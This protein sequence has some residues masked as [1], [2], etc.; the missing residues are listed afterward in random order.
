MRISVFI[1]VGFALI[2]SMFSLTTYINYQLAEQV[3]EN[4]EWVSQSTI[5]VRHSNRFQRN[6]LNMISGLRGYLLS[7]ERYFL[8]TYDSAIAE[9]EEILRELPELMTP[10]SNQIKSLDEIHDLH[11]QWVKD[12]AAPLIAAKNNA[13]ESDS[14]QTVFQRLYK[15][16]LN[17]GFEVRLNNVLMSKMRDFINYEYTLR[18]GRRDELNTIIDKTGRISVL[19]TTTSVVT[20]LLIAIFLA[21]RIST[22]IVH[23]V[24]VSQSIASGNYTV[25]MDATGKDE[26]GKL[27]KSMN[28]M[29]SVLAENISLLK[30][31]NQELDQFA[32]IVSHDMKAPL[33]GIDNVVTWIEEDH[34][35]ELSPK[36]KEYM[37]LIKGRLVRA[38]NLI[39][40]I[41]W[42]SRVGREEVALES[43]DVNQLVYEV[44]ENLPQHNGISI[45]PE[46]NLPTITAER[47]P[48]SQVFTNLISNAIKYHDKPN[49]IIRIYH[50]DDGTQYTFYVAD[51]GP[52]I[53]KNY[54]NKIF[55]IFQTLNEN[56][57]FENTGVGLAIVKKILDDR[58]Q[59]ITV[60]SEEGK[61][62]IFSF[63]W[64]K[65]QKI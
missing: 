3:T 14:A 19:L 12:V 53:S 21:H 52:G 6:L 15:T 47:V 18:E 16:Q 33:R 32:H 50:R 45:Q 13:G 46:K 10:Q 7:G 9:N 30:R 5:V 35:H 24:N 65:T 31:K 62:S 39:R 42:Y 60:E 59:Q 41:L 57:S 36:V 29:A 56:N 64:P 48:L 37:D 43:V 22:R 40:G 17:S 49:G 23:M 1:L 44:I 11:S 25:R 58:K 8:Q 2:L 38:E 27:A 55:V 61:G 63:T 4:T 26:L 51:N 20:G 34:W 28:H 54:H